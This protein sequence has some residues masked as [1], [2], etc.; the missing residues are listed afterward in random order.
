MSAHL[1]APIHF[2]FCIQGIKELLTSMRSSHF[3][4]KDFDKTLMTAPPRWINGS[5]MNVMML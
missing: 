1:L 5:R 2:N 4:V 3:T